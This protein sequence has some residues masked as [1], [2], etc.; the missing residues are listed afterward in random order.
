MKSKPEIN[1]LSDFF[2]KAF[3]DKPE[4]MDK[5]S[6]SDE[7][8]HFN[9]AYPC[10]TP[11]IH[12]KIKKHLDPESNQL[13]IIYTR[14]LKAYG[15]NTDTQFII[16]FFAYGAATYPVFLKNKTKLLDALLLRGS[17]IRL[18]I[19]KT[20]GLSTE[21]FIEVYDQILEGWALSDVMEIKY[22]SFLPLDISAMLTKVQLGVIESG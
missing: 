8:N 15:S 13:F 1:D 21:N 19:D 17:Q 4:L 20:E 9:K 7:G 22:G 5:L 12:E 11:L 14:L 2:E 3:K 10:E 18:L 6:K 16:D